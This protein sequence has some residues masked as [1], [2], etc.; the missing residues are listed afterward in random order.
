MQLLEQAPWLEIIGVF[1]GILQVLNA[2]K[3]RPVT[4]V[5]GIIS[6]L[7]TIYIFYHEGWYAETVLNLYYLVMSFYG[8]YVWQFQTKNQKAI[9]IAFASSREKWIS[10]GIILVAFITFY[11][12]ITTFTESRD[13][14]WDALVASFAWAGMWL[15][16]KRK[17]EN[18]LVL[19]ISNLIAIPLQIYREK[20]FYA[21]LTLFL[22]IVAFVS[23]VEW[24]KQLQ[25]GS[26]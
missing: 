20:Y 6:V 1:F 13:V 19:N 26:N 22:T 15:M 8:L 11:T 24:R 5:Y 4:Y 18:W 23:Y 14:L 2:R 17:V 9:P 12:V 25:S 7:I 10:A 21:G 3:N 16:A